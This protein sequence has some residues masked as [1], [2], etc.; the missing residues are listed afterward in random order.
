[1]GKLGHEHQMAARN[2]CA[3][4]DAYR[5]QKSGGIQLAQV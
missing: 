5:A 2:C 3:Y 1:M 4:Q